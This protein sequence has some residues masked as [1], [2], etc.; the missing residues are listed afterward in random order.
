MFG[1]KT[2]ILT[3]VRLLTSISITAAIDY[4]PLP[5]VPRRFSR[6]RPCCPHPTRPLSMRSSR[7][8][9]F[10]CGLTRPLLLPSSRSFVIRQRPFSHPHL[11]V[12]GDPSYCQPSGQL[13][14]HN[15]SRK[16]EPS[17]S[18]FTPDSRRCSLG[19][20]CPP[21]APAPLSLHCQCFVFAIDLSTGLKV[22]RRAV[23]SVCHD[24]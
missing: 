4:K 16:N 5:T 6:C 14:P 21:H 22:M 11:A 15:L 24:G 20:S 17:V 3:L 13:G 10:C 23:V 7:L 18:T 1:L 2:A 9:G 19:L 12:V 8:D